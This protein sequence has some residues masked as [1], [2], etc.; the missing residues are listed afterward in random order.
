MKRDNISGTLGAMIEAVKD[1]VPYAITAVEEFPKIPHVIPRGFFGRIWA[2]ILDKPTFE[3]REA[4][5]TVRIVLIT[6]DPEE[7]RCDVE[8][9]IEKV[10]P[11]GVWV[12][13]DCIE[14]CS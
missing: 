9:A 2:A 12:F 5:G 6:D 7:D 4:I 14:E 11:A 10:R 8:A 13:I 3:I 1:A